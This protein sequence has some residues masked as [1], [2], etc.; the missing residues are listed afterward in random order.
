MADRRKIQ[1]LEEQ[2]WRARWPL[3]CISRTV[4]M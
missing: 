3:G 2:V 1:R 4:A